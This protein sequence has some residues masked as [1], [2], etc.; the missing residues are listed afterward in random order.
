MIW[1]KRA[2]LRLSA[3]CLIFSNWSCYYGYAPQRVPVYRD[4]PVGMRSP[5]SLQRLTLDLIEEFNISPQSLQNLHYY[6]ENGLVLYQAASHGSSAITAN[7]ELVLRRQTRQNEIVFQ[8]LARGRTVSLQE[9]FQFFRFRSVYKISVYFA[10]SSPYYRVS[11]RYYALTFAPNS[12]GE[13]VLEK[14]FWG[15][16]VSFGGYEYTI[17]EAQAENFLLVEVHLQDNY[18]PTRR[19]MPAEQRY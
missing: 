3:L 12:H 10:E 2:L 15:N 8:H 13:Y 17:S 16:T 11:P 4:A 14:S 7:G 5:S 9:E 19:M 18:T 6:L 1:C